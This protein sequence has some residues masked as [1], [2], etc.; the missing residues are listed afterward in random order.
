MTDARNI[1]P[2]VTPD[3]KKVVVPPDKKL[4]KEEEAYDPASA[5]DDESP[6][7]DEQYD[8]FTEYQSGESAANLN[9]SIFSCICILFEKE[10]QI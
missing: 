7:E 10:R 1:L 6:P 3:E 5:F 4:E 2:F 9:S 8:P